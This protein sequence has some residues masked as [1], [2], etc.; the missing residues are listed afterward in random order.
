LHLEIRGVW[1]RWPVAA[2]QAQFRCGRG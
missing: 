2:G 1:R